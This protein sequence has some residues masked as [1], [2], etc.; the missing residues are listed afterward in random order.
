VRYR[1]SRIQGGHERGHG[2]L[3]LSPLRYASTHPA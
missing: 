2:L 1:R 3:E